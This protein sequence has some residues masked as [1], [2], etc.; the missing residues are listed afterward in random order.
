[1][2]DLVLYDTTLCKGP[3]GAEGSS[4]LLLLGKDAPEKSWHSGCWWKP[5]VLSMRFSSN[6]GSAHDLSSSLLQVVSWGWM[7][8]PISVLA[9]LLYL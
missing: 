6:P 3:G 1:M 2:W 5:A 9:H 7:F 4:A 8:P